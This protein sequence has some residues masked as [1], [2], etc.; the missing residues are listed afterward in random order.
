M[1]QIKHQAEI[2]GRSGCHRFVVSAK[3]GLQ[4]RTSTR[5]RKLHKPINPAILAVNKVD[6]PEM[7]NDIFGFL[8]ARLGETA[9]NFVCP[10][11]RYG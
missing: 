3:K 11:Y 4:M 10:R 2:A 8:C 6:N 1:E 7:R 5:A 9:A